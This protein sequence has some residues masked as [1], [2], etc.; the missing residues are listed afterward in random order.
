[1]PVTATASRETDREMI[2]KEVDEAFGF[3]EI[4]TEKFKIFI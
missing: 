1:M 4:G 2:V 3:A